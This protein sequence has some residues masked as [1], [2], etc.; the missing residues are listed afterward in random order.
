MK[1][2]LWLVCLPIWAAVA[3]TNPVASSVGLSNLPPVEAKSSVSGFDGAAPAPDSSVPLPAESA[4]RNFIPADGKPKTPSSTDWVA[5]DMLKKKEE[6]QKKEIEQARLAEEKARETQPGLDKEKK[7]KEASERS[8]VQPAV[9]KAAVPGFGQ[10]DAQKLPVVTGL[11]GVKPRA[12]ESGDGRVQP[13]FNSFTGPS[14]TGPLGNDYQSGAKPIMPGS[15]ST[16]GRMQVPPQPPSG[17]Y[18]KISQDPY[19]SPPS[20]VEKKSTV[21]PPKP[22]ATLPNPPSGDPKRVIENSKAGLSPYD[23]SK[24]VP[25]PRSQRRF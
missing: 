11:D 25:D 8:S 9:A 5:Q 2:T 14:S 13:G 7:D 12:M 19:S 4:P 1:G 6:A 22:V 23:N 16:D 20:L 18:K 15:V 24:V 3:Q 10:S 17:A 21:P